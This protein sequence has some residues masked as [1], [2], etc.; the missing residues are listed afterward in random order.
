MAAPTQRAITNVDVLVVGSGAGGLAAA[1]AARVLGLQVL[2]VEK[3]PVFG[4]TTAWSG[5]W[6]WIPGNRHARAADKAGDVASARAYLGAELG[7]WFDAP[8]IDAYLEHGPRMVD[9]FEAETCLRFVPGHATPDFHAASPGASLGRVICALPFDAR[10]LGGLV[11][12][13]RP[14]LPEITLMGMAIA[15][16]A[17]LRHFMQ[18]T[19]SAASAWYATR[20]LARH[21]LDMLRYRRGMHLVNG[22]ALV[23]RLL[24]AAIDRGVGLWSEAPAARLV[25]NDGAIEGAIVT[26]RDGDVHVKARSGVVL[27]CGGFPHDRER[28]RALF[29]ATPTGLE[30][31]S[32][33]P[34]DNTGDGLRLAEGAGGVVDAS[35]RSAGAWCPVSRVTHRDGRSGVFPHL[36]D[37]A[38]PGVIAVRADGRRFVNEA[39]SYHDFMNALFAATPADEPVAAWLLT[40]HATL[41]RYGLGFVKP[42]PF[43]LQP[44]LR[45]GYLARG[46][47]LDALARACG[48]DAAALATTIEAY[49]RGARE[50]R[51]DAFGRGTTPFNRFGGDAERAPNPCVAP[52][53]RPPFYAVKVLPGSL[54]T[55]AGVKTDAR[56][57]VLS[58]DGTPIKGL[59]AVGNDMASVMAGHYPSG[60]IT[61]GPAMTFGYLAARD[62]AGDSDVERDAR[63]RMERIDR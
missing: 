6:L 22:N 27:A 63:V 40:D 14:P 2:V 18:A 5:G 20:R 29:P 43:R 36:I 53:E 23:A 13:L 58:A 49:N 30:H 55:F 4:G 60:G 46:T 45:S 21:A 38:R 61:L 57:R 19:R 41:R 44:H 7:R 11:D 1:V 51:D 52:L 35:G 12:K 26:T 42:F 37:R 62:L 24:K 47:T 15:A 54:G 10:E 39:D 17:D 34:G 50:G 56:A 32:A 31:W 16:G 25:A 3:A 59:Y 33:A 8:R 9:F 48:I 28:R